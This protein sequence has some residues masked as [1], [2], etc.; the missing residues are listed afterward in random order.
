M[1]KRKKLLYSLILIFALTI[2]GAFL[3]AC[4]SEVKVSPLS[5]A[6]RDTNQ[7]NI[8]L[9]WKYNNTEI[10]GDSYKIEYNGRDFVDDLEIA[11]TLNSTDYYIV[12]KQN[13][14]TVLSQNGNNTATPAKTPGNYTISVDLG[15]EY[16]ISNPSIAL[17]ITKADVAISWEIDGSVFTDNQA[18]YNGQDLKNYISISLGENY[19]SSDGNVAY[20]IEY[21]DRS[22][23]DYEDVDNIKDAGTY[24]LTLIEQEEWDNLYNISGDMS[25]TITITPKTVDVAWDVDNDYTNLITE[26]NDYASNKQ[27]NMSYLGRNVSEKLYVSTSTPQIEVA[28]TKNNEAVN[29]VKNVGM[30]TFT[31]ST[32]NQNYALTNTVVKLNIESSIRGLHWQIDGENAELLTNE[33][34]EREYRTRGYTV[35]LFYYD[36]ETDTTKTYLTLSQNAT[37]TNV[38]TYTLSSDDSNDNVF[39]D[40][41]EKSIQLKITEKEIWVVA[42]SY[43][44]NY[45]DELIP[46]S[47]LTYKL[48]STYSDGNGT[49]LN[50][51][52]Y[53]DTFNIVLKYVDDSDNTLSDE[54]ISAEIA[55]WK[56]DGTNNTKQFKIVVDDDFSQTNS[57][58]TVTFIPGIMTISLKQVTITYL[59]DGVFVDSE[60]WYQTQ[61]IDLASKKGE[62]AQYNHRE[63]T[64][65]FEV[66]S[67]NGSNVVTEIG[68][69]QYSVQTDASLN[70]YY[71]YYIYYLNTEDEVI[72]Q[73]QFDVRTSTKYPDRAAVAEDDL[74][75]KFAYTLAGWGVQ[76]K[77]SKYYFAQ[78]D[79]NNRFDDDY[80]LTKSADRNDIYLCPLFDPT[81]YQIKCK[82]VTDD[83]AQLGEDTFY[84]TILDYDANKV[85]TVEPDQVEGYQFEG[86]YYNGIKLANN[87]FTVNQFIPDRNK[88]DDK[89]EEG[90]KIVMYLEGR[91]ELYKCTI[92]I[93]V[94]NKTVW[95]IAC[96]RDQKINKR[97]I[98]SLIDRK[99]G[100]IYIMSDIPD[101]A[102]A[103]IIT[104]RVS[105]IPLLWI[106]IGVIVVGGIAA[107]VI[108]KVVRRRRNDLDRKKLDI[109][110]NKL[111]R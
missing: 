16:I 73:T 55:E 38:G 57:N 39:F 34:N 72:G 48:Y 91:Y 20:S 107:F 44:K 18:E 2:M 66:K 6:I 97:Q 24:T 52:V 33:A 19:V 109:I 22:N 37:V 86:L 62:I 92:T 58:Y 94:N 61:T 56:Y 93:T 89:D 50:T 7:T 96:D 68:D 36:D 17:E 63:V 110:M 106:S 15:D 98:E 13:V 101:T 85:F 27:Y 28:I 26:D 75:T 100:Y 32:D 82:Y 74:P 104:V 23:T 108:V 64:S 45:A 54:N 80:V 5:R 53:S 111:D 70:L 87:Q 51:S 102:N 46:T 47:A 1:E 43:N 30:Y 59:L 3:V 4:D 76:G 95:T 8:T 10:T 88:I 40:N 65:W 99:F 83:N 81:K 21:T 42:D 69:N 29:E 9:T 11:Y 49:L 78:T 35:K 12:D 25:Q 60:E 84:Y 103:S 77:S 67:V 71:I 90:K 41:S 79:N 31:A 14:S 105:E